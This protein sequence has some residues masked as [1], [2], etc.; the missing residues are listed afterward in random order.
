MAMLRIQLDAKGLERALK[1]AAANCGNMRQ[2]WEEV[3]E[4]VERSVG[5]NFTAQGRPKA[6]KKTNEATLK[7]R[8]KGSKGAKT[9]TDTR[10][11]RNSITREVSDRDVEV[12]TNIIYANTHQHGR[13][14]IPARPFLLIQEE[15]EPK[16]ESAIEM[17]IGR[18]L[19]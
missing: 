2:A 12:G 10:R 16:I 5:K 13:G 18:P 4:I 17:H 8:R 1:A 9:L 14:S 19:V 15:D 11:L 6:W 7:R 3:G